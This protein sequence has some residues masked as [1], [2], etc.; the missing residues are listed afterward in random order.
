MPETA[1]PYARSMSS[2]RH[3]ALLRIACECSPTTSVETSDQ[4]TGPPSSSAAR[5]GPHATSAPPSGTPPP[6][7]KRFLSDYQGRDVLTKVELASLARRCSYRGRGYLSG[8]SSAGTMI[9]PM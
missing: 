1:A 3:L 4:E 2:P 6:A 7:P 9:L 5:Y 8:A